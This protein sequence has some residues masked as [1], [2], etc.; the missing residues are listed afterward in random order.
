MMTDLH[1]SNQSTLHGYYDALISWWE[2]KKTAN[3]REIAR[4]WIDMSGTHEQ[5]I[6]ALAKQ[7]KY[8]AAEDLRCGCVPFYQVLID[9]GIRKTNWKQIAKRLLKPVQDVDQD[10][11]DDE[12]PGDEGPGQARGQATRQSPSYPFSNR[13]TREAFYKVLSDWWMDPDTDPLAIGRAWLKKKSHAEA[14]TSLARALKRDLHVRFT[15]EENQ[16]VNALCLAGLEGVHWDQVAARLL[17]RFRAKDDD[18]SDDEDDDS[19]GGPKAPDPM[20]APIFSRSERN[21]LD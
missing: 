12:Q 9:S 15:E 13:Q 10:A 21:G 1:F 16:F 2:D 4:S 8:T 18:A 7:L 20:P 17:Q 3:P 19:S 6:A 5:A 14:V 11:D